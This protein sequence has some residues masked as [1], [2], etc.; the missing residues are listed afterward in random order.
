MEMYV[1]LQGVLTKGEI[2]DTDIWFVYNSTIIFFKNAVE[3]KTRGNVKRQGKQ[4]MGPERSFDSSDFL[5]ILGSY[6]KILYRTKLLNTVQWEN[7]KGTIFFFNF[8]L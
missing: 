2:C 7:T 3:H 8:L 1:T 5:A 4:E 6:I